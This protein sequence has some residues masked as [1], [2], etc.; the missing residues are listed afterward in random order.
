VAVPAPSPCTASGGSAVAIKQA[1]QARETNFLAVNFIKLLPFSIK[2]QF[3]NFEHLK[4]NER[5]LL[6]GLNKLDIC[7]EIRI[8]IETDL[9][10][11]QTF[12]AGL[13]SSYSI[14]SRVG[15]SRSAAYVRPTISVASH[16][17]PPRWD[18]EIGPTERA[19]AWPGAVHQY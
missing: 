12:N 2:H 10:N 9:Q 6:I 7:Q 11:Y 13:T 17:L 3:N 8:P 14:S 4:I 5:A 16:S 1:A 15:Y 18:C 19:A